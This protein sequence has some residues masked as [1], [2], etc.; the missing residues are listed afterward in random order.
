MKTYS[1]YDIIPNLTQPTDYFVGIF[2]DTEDPDIET[3]HRHS[4]YSIVWF[5]QGCGMNV[6]DFS[7]YEILPNRIFTIN[8]KQIHN[9]SYSMNSEGYFL[10]I[11]EHLARQLNIHFDSPF[12]DI[13][14][15]DKN[16]LQEIFVRMLSA[17]PSLKAKHQQNSIAIPY[18]CSL[19]NNYAASKANVNPKLIDFRKLITTNYETNHTIEQCAEKLDISAEELNLI[20]KRETGLSP[21][22][23]QLDLKITEIKRLLL[24]TLLN[25]SEIAYQTGFD[26]S[27]YF[28]RIFKK[29]TGL[30]PTLFRE[31]YLNTH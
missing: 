1:I 4:Y 12:V 31:K 5:M 30:S 8:P 28:S 24:Y 16:F 3:N 29:K 11:E 23:L 14:D 22:Q 17:H 20:C 15:S 19:I 13:K 2:E 27:S 25:T 26:D 7:E 18:L 10:M 6:I 21:K 9:W